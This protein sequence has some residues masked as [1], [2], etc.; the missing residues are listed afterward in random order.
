MQKLAFAF[1]VEE[2][3]TILGLLHEK[4]ETPQFVNCGVD[5]FK[6]LPRVIHAASG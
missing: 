3:E 2:Y 1:R 5:V 6:V 4:K